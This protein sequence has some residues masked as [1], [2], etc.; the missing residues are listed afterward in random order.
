[1]D[2]QRLFEAGEAGRCPIET[3]TSRSRIGLSRHRI[4][5]TAP[6]ITSAPAQDAHILMLHIR[7]QPAHDFWADGRHLPI[8]AAPAGALG[9]VDLGRDAE[10]LFAAEVDSLHLHL[11]RLALEDLAAEARATPVS[12]FA[13]DVHRTTDDAVARQLG[14]LLAAALEAP[15]QASQLYVDHLILAFATHAATRYGGMRPGG[16]PRGGLAP[17]QLRRAQE[18]LAADLTG[19]T[20]LQEV[21]EA[22]GLS[23]SYFARAFRTST[24]TTPHAWLQARRVDRALTLLRDAEL[25]LAEVALR[26]GFADQSHFSRVFKNA[27][28]T[29]P[30]AW[31]RNAIG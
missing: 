3:R 17:W 29:T 22:C 26:A 14:P 1:M 20:S 9:M 12:R 23:L 21:A 25:P 18:W 7:D 24:G 16:V 28:G 13:S 15:E 30:G 31:R 8:G 19:A 4:A 27:T 6:T 2:K 11:P 10:A 5:T